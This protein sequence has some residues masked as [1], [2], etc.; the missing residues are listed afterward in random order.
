MVTSSTSAR[1]RVVGMLDDVGE[2]AN[3]VL[4]EI[5]GVSREHGL[6]RRREPSLGDRS[7]PCRRALR[8]VCSR[9]SKDLIE[10]TIS[11]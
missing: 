10:R 2:L 1:A 6:A 7:R 4:R 3:A 9:A 8:V 11:P 5:D